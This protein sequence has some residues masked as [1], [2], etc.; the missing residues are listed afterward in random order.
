LWLVQ[1]VA[2]SESDNT[3]SCVYYPNQE[4]FLH[5]LFIKAYEL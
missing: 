3:P 1:L 2:E 5:M 4:F